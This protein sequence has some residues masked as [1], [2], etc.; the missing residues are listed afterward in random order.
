MKFHNIRKK[1]K[2]LQKQKEKGKKQNIYKKNQLLLKWFE[3]S[4]QHSEPEHHG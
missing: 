3:T 2:I 1:D 4:Q